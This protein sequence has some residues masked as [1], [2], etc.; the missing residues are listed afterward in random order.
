MDAHSKIGASSASRWFACP[1]SVRLSESA[2]PERLS[3]YA[4][5]GTAA[6]WV[7]EQFFTEWK[8]TDGPIALN[9]WLDEYIGAVAPNGVELESEDIDSVMQFIV[10][11]LEILEGGKYVLHSEVKF[12]LSAIYPGLYG[13]GDIVL[14]ETNMKRLK[15]LDYKHGSGVPVEVVDNKQLMY[16]G[17]GAIQFV[18]KKHELDYLNVMGWGGVFKE[19]EISVVQPRCRHRDGAHRAWIVP[20]A[21]LD[22]FAMELKRAA[23]LT[24]A[25][26][27]PFATGDHCRWCRALAICPTFNRT[28]QEIAKTDFTPISSPSNL[29]LPAPESLTKD[30]MVKVLRFADIFAEWIK[31]CEANAL[32]RLEHGEEMPGFKLVKKKANRAW[33]DE[34]NAREVLSL[35]LSE[36]ELYKPLE[37]I[38]P[39]AAEK[40]L[41]KQK[42]LIENLVVK[43][44]TG[45]TLAPDHD[46]R[47][48]VKG[49]AETDFAAV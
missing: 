1:G 32:H 3:Q 30:E 29:K 41:K 18:C 23:E 13:T 36:E 47:E 46:P 9:A 40:L 31:A 19:V 25:K 8:K 15:V 5:R 28:T 43:P 39:A 49:S 4:E 24:T 21:K 33:K 20:P 45:N 12:D 10:I 48:A 37:F 27:A 7:I 44:D 34:D 35:V 17:L 16:Y 11:V 14:M 2:P 22:A 38:S 6:H 26:D 42:K